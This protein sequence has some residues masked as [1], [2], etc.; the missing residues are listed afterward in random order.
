MLSCGRT[1]YFQFTNAKT[2][3]VE[4]E[5]SLTQGTTSLS[6][7]LTIPTFPAG[8]QPEKYDLVPEYVIRRI[9][10]YNMISVQTCFALSSDRTT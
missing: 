10:D 6:S 1:A 2:P 5:T 4:Y 8:L 9:I 3:F 7:V